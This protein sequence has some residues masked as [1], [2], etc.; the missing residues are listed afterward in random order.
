MSAARL[1]LAQRLYEIMERLDPSQETVAW[2]D[3]PGLDRDF[4]VTCIR[5]LEAERAHWLE[6]MNE[7]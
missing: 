3:L 5:H 1:A 7:K 6:L 4:Y 2:A